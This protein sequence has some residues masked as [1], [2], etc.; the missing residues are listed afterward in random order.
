MVALSLNWSR[1]SKLSLRAA[2]PEAFFI[3][4]QTVFNKVVR[5]KSRS[6]RVPGSSYNVSRSCPK[7]TATQRAQN[8]LIYTGR[9]K[10][11][12]PVRVRIASVRSSHPEIEHGLEAL[13]PQLSAVPPS[14]GM[15]Q[16]KQVLPSGWW[17]W[18]RGLTLLGSMRVPMRVPAVRQE[19]SY[20]RPIELST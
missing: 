5:R 15:L 8:S 1:K 17:S 9:P 18:D 20:T 10:F 4:L 7:R 13:R 14:G 11:L 6:F 16:I 19:R 3:Q 2:R 12:W